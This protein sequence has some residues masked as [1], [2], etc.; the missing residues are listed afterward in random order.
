[1]NIGETM[2]KEERSSEGR[3]YMK[4]AYNKQW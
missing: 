3:S 2:D 1:M 4:P